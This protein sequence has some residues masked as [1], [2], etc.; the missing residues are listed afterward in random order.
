MFRSLGKEKNF[1]GLEDEFSTFEHSLVVVVSAPYARGEGRG[2][3]TADAPARILKASRN[4]EWF[5][6]ETKREIARERGIA[7]LVP[8]N[9]A[10]KSDE[11]ALQEIN[12]STT[13]LLSLNK[14]VVTLGGEHTIS[15]ATVAAYAKKFPGLSVLQFDAHAELRDKFQGNKYSHAS[16]MARVCEFLDPGRLVQVGIRS[17]S[18]AE[19]EFARDHGV[20]TFY[21]HEIRNGNYARLLKTWDDAVVEALTDQVY[22]SFDM[23]AFDPS[24][25]PATRSPQPNGLFWDEVTRCLKKLGRKK[26]IV[27][28]DVVELSPI[29]G[30]HYPET[31]AAKLV[32]KTLNY[33]L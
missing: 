26:K 8:L 27:G 5:D 1:L 7:T 4:V 22:V 18:R 30:L 31:T 2:M 25:V 29:E 16:V 21:A 19:A 15:S 32:S 11:A 3:S 14:F 12:E 28:L 24:V 23:S 9:F 6:E 20:R 13:S 33:A 17:Q 10:R